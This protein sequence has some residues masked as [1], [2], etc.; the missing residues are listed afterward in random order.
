MAS[1]NVL[2][3]QPPFDP[4]IR[5]LSNPLMASGAGNGGSL[6]NDGMSLQRGFM[7]WDTKGGNL[8]YTGGPFGDGRD[9]LNFLYN[10]S[11]VSSDYNV[12][13]ASLQAAML[14][15][16]PGNS[17]TLLAPLQQS[18]SW[19]LYY[20]R[21]YEL[22]YGTGTNGK[23]TGKPNDPA[24]IGV[25]ADVLQVMQFTGLLAN[26]SQSNTASWLT[27]GVAGQTSATGSH[28][29]ANT[30]FSVNNGGIM[31]MMPCFVYFGNAA[32]TIDNPGNPNVNAGAINYQ[33]SYYGYISEFSVNYT[34]WTS[35]MVP[36]RCTID[37]NFTM[38]PQPSQSNIQSVL[39]D[40]NGS[41][42]LLTPGGPPQLSPGGNSAAYSPSVA[43]I[44]GR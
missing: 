18:V 13:N 1:K 4:R 9:K 33:L 19:E 14:Y 3:T 24:V 36:I 2:M 16:V 43:G 11:T 20:D 30:S 5:S 27:G 28:I 40:L 29:G 38:L 44:G 7:V 34:H 25:Q 39:G 22:N 10:P 17:G 32:N 35:N 42:T 8:G 21:T 15:P 6:K 41:G 26:L 12:G 31:V 37:I 23:G